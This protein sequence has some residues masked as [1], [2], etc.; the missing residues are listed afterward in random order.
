MLNTRKLFFLGSIFA[1]VVFSSGATLAEPQFGGDVEEYL[2]CDPRCDQLIGYVR[3]GDP[4]GGDNGEEASY[5]VTTS[6]IQYDCQPL[7]SQTK[8]IIG[9]H[10]EDEETCQ[11]QIRGVCVPVIDSN[12]NEAKGKKIVFYGNS[13]NDCNSGLDGDA[14]GDGKTEMI[15]PDGRTAD[16]GDDDEGG[17]SGGS[18]NATQN[19]THLTTV[20]GVKADGTGA[21]H[22][23]TSDNQDNEGSGTSHMETSDH[24][25]YTGSGDSVFTSSGNDSGYSPGGSGQEG[26][27]Y[28]SVGGSVGSGGLQS[29]VVLGDQD[30]MKEKTQKENKLMEE[31]NITDSYNAQKT[32]NSEVLFNLLIIVGGIGSAG[33]FVFRSVRK[34]VN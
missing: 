10:I 11:I 9:M 6:T 14:S 5:V 27:G 34:L 18:S 15:T 16:G 32:T 19:D 28:G 2:V 33:Y 22:M 24:R 8:E 25:D 17:P 1:G 30:Q 29:P 31:L 23:N 20:D 21:T 7:S 13:K 4:H 26:Q 12:G 3:V